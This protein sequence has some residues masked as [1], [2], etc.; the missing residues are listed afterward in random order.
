VDSRLVPSITFLDFLILCVDSY[1]WVIISNLVTELYT[2]FMIRDF[3]V[4]Y[5]RART[6]L[7]DFLSQM[8]AI[9]RY[10][11]IFQHSFPV[12][13]SVS[14]SHIITSNEDKLFFFSLWKFFP[15]RIS[16]CIRELSFFVN[17]VSG[18]TG[19]SSH[20]IAGF[21]FRRFFWKKKSSYFFHFSFNSL[22][23]VLSI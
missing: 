1:T 8:N 15:F 11:C 17:C 9:S 20:D 7:P 3:I 19:V 2:F 14:F 18:R 5:S 6:F 21:N 16:S 12:Y 4:L 23:C 22:N 10:Y 13:L